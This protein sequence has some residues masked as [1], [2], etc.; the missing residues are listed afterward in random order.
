MPT[1]DVFDETRYFDS[2]AKIEVF[3][4]K[5]RVLGINVCEDAWNHP[6]FWRGRL[7]YS[8]DPIDILAGKKP[9]LLINISGS[10]F[11]RGKDQLRYRL[12]RH[13]AA[14][15]GLPFVFVNQ[16]G[17][18]DELIF[19]GRSLCLDKNG[20]PLLICPPFREFVSTVDTS[21]KGIPSSFIPQNEIE[22][23]HQALLLG[24]RDYLGKSG[25][26][27]AVVGLSGGIDS[28]VTFA[29]AAEALGRENV[30][31]ISMPSMYS[32]RGSVEDSRVLSAISGRNSRLFPSRAF[33]MNTYPVCP[34]IFKVCPRT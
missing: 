8:I 30:L 11:F 33:T 20:D 13:H 27:S 23:V 26:K 3:R 21:Q 4:F 1:Y 14:K 12:I 17:G 34:P 25:F 7:L 16:V 9:D 5:D 18:N 29:L 22:S 2:A 6:D 32:S 10:P 28:A 24:I 15:H 19:D 31:G